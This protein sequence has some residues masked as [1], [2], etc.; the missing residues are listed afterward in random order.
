MDEMNDN[1]DNIT[2]DENGNL[3]WTDGAT[4]SN[5]MAILLTAVN[6]WRSLGF[7]VDIDPRPYHDL[8]EQA[9][10]TIVDNGFIAAYEKGEYDI[11]GMDYQ[12]I[13]AH[14]LYNLAMFS[15]GYS[16]EGSLLKG[17]TNEEYDA[18]LTEA[19]KESD[20]GK[21]AEILRSAE[22]LLVADEAAVI[23]VVFNANAYVVSGELSKVKTDF[24][25]VQIFTKAQLKNYV[26]Y[27]PS[28]KAAA[29]SEE[30]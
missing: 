28:V 21:R 25:G 19:F 30:E 27:L 7:S 4:P 1:L 14:A 22:K 13:S 9:D 11:V 6:A 23:P 5:E 29:P 2:E 3:V 26:Q 24:W 12:M 8:V 10:G 15:S 17:Y 18:L 20:L 16:G